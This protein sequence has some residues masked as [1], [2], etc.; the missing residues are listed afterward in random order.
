MYEYIEGK[1]TVKKVDYVAIDINGAAYKIFISLK[2]YE[3]IKNSVEKLY[4]HTYVREDI[5][6]LYGFYSEEERTVFEIVLNATGVGPK[7]AV[8]ILSTYTTEE[9]KEII[10]NEDVKML[11]KVPGIGVKKGQKLILDI[12]DKMNLLNVTGSEK[13][14]S[15]NSMLE[16]DILLAMESLGYGAKDLEKL[17][18]KEEMNSY[19]TIEQAIKDILKKIRK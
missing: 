4:I 15:S 10:V 18:S 1:I 3:S 6:K 7:L 8:A 19:T 9:I 5:L 11:S 12:K 14:Q 2:T 17:V 13:K 16:Q